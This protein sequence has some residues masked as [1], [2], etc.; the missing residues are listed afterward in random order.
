MGWLGGCDRVRAAWGGLCL[1]GQGKRREGWGV[2]WGW[3]G[4]GGGGGGGVFL[5]GGG[6]EVSE[7]LGS[8]FMRFVIPLCK[9]ELL[10]PGQASVPLCPIV[11]PRN[12]HRYFWPSMG[13]PL[14]KTRV[15]GDIPC[16]VASCSLRHIFFPILLVY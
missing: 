8:S 4:G 14:K 12:V 5:R 16:H 3:G 2:G 7:I 11:T 1:G 15:A 13:R 6:V 9:K 10:V